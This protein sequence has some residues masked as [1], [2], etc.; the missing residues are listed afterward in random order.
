M[1]PADVGAAVPAAIFGGFRRRHARRYRIWSRYGCPYSL[2][3]KII[4][5][6]NYHR[7][8]FRQNLLRI[9]SLFCVAREV[10]HFPA[11]AAIE[12]IAKLRSVFRSIRPRKAAKIKSQ[13][14]CQRYNLGTDIRLIRSARSYQ[15]DDLIRHLRDAVTGGVDAIVCRRLIKR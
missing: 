11:L 15:C 3:L 13:L 6:E 14:P 1:R 4:E 5:R 12:P 10:I 8:R 7:F 9:A 2:S